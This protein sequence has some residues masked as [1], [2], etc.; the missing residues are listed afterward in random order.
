MGGS[1]DLQRLA[2]A[3][4]TEARIDVAALRQNFARARA[5]AGDRAVIAVV[6][7]DAY[8]HGIGAVAPALFAAGARH[9]AVATVAEGV[10]LRPLVSD[11]MI[12][13]LGGFRTLEERDATIEHRL[14]PVVRSR[15]DLDGLR[16]V[17]LR[18]GETVGVHVELDTGMRRL[19]ASEED[20]HRLVHGAKSNVGVRLKGVFTHFARAD[21]ADGSH[22][23]E[24][25]ARF[26]RFVETAQARG[27]DPELVHAA[28]SPALFHFDSIASA[29]PEQNAVRPGL[30]LY[31]VSPGPSSRSDL[32]PVMTLATSIVAIRP[33]NPGDAVGYGGTY[34]ATRPTRIATLPLGYA[35]G[36]PW[37]LGNRGEALLRGRRVPFAGRVSMDFVTVDLGDGPGE[38]GDEVILFGVGAQGSLPVEEVAAAAGTIAYELLV[39][40]GPR[41]PRRVDGEDGPEAFPSH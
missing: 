41:V 24:P 30:L 2:A 20:A 3:R 4:R 5:L 14:S 7:A 22:C 32:A 37:S 31:G 36:V 26:R 8:G 6:K 13:V 39:R 1:A 16:R 34:R 9:F 11:A 33:A 23:I 28:N 17:A 38:V 21:E 19:G 25:L 10:A 40:V 18:H 15:A 29:M 35:D 12:L 27:A